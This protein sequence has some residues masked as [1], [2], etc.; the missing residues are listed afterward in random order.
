MK[1]TLI[2]GHLSNDWALGSGKPKNDLIQKTWLHSISPHLGLGFYVRTYEHTFMCGV[3]PPP[4]NVVLCL[5]LSTLN[6]CLR[7]NINLTQLISSSVA[8]PAQLVFLLFLATSSLIQVI[9][10]YSKLLHVHVDVGTRFLTDRVKMW[11]IGKWRK[12][13]KAKAT[14]FQNWSHLTLKLFVFSALI[15]LAFC[16]FQVYL[17]ISRIGW[18]FLG[19]QR[20]TFYANIQ[21]LI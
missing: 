15:E 5:G 7:W 10:R 19:E 12:H 11:W 1:L 21:C 16:N 8:L 2:Q 14:A 6:L 3:P 4:L 20:Q 13:I 9:G 17:L 18:K